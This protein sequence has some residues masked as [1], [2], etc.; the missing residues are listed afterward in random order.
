MT[1]QPP[2]TTDDHSP[3]AK[4][5]RHEASSSD[6]KRTT[7]RTPL[8]RYLRARDRTLGLDQPNKRQPEF[9]PSSL[10]ERLFTITLIAALSLPG[11]LFLI[12]G[13]DSFVTNRFSAKGHS[14]SGFPARIFAIAFVAAS[15]AWFRFIC[16]VFLGHGTKSP[17]QDSMLLTLVALV[18]ATMLVGLLML[19]AG[20]AL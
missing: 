17:L 1:D 13:I 3:K 7:T 14:W 15:L 10:S 2:T 4:D 20:V 5:S 18:A 16:C 19:F 9:P 11:M 6:E 8:E 12:A